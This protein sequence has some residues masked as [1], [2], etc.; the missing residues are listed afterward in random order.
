MSIFQI[1]VAVIVSIIVLY[2]ISL[3]FK[4]SANVKD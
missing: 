2:E 4:E 1:A 3:S